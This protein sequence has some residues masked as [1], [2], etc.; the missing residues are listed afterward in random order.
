MTPRHPAAYLVGLLAGA[1]CMVA[2]MIGAWLGSRSFPLAALLAF[3]VAALT[4]EAARRRAPVAPAGV[5][6]VELTIEEA[7]ALDHMHV[8]GE[9]GLVEFS[10][11]RFGWTY[12][13]E[14]ED[15]CDVG[16][17]EQLIKKGRAK[18]AGTDEHGRR[19]VVSVRPT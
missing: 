13:G 14:I 8:E 17:V 1:C 5:E 6:F 19:R 15:H 4:Y 9:R 2:D 10:P 12:Y 18:N 7:I 3:L 16:V 11:G